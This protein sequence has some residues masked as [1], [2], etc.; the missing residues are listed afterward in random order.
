[1]ATGYRPKI[2]GTSRGNTWGQ[3]YGSHGNEDA[4]GALKLGQD[5]PYV[6]ER[7]LGSNPYIQMIKSDFGA[8]C[9][10]SKRPFHV[11]KWTN[12]ET[13]RRMKTVICYEAASV[14]NCCQ[15]CMNDMT[16]GVPLVIRDALMKAAGK[17]IDQLPESEVGQS[18]YFNQKDKEAAL[19]ASGAVGIATAADPRL[20]LEAAAKQIFNG[21]NGGHNGQN[22]HR[23]SSSSSS[24]SSSGQSRKRQRPDESN[25]TTIW[26]ATKIKNEQIL[27][28]EELIQNALVSFGAIRQIRRIENKGFA[29]IEFEQ[30]ADAKTVL[31]S[32]V[33]DIA[34]IAIIM[35]WADKQ[36]NNYNNNNNNNK[37]H[38]GNNSSNNNNS[39]RQ[40]NNNVHA[41][42]RTM[43]AAMQ[44]TTWNGVG[45]AHGYQ[46]PPMPSNMRAFISNNKTNVPIPVMFPIP[47]FEQAK[48][49]YP[50]M[51]HT[52]KSVKE[53][54]KVD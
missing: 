46:V 29:F 39:S 16:Y 42:N 48:I 7:C 9:K 18:F 17:T 23:G 3:Q 52:K 53:S 21:H 10:I 5:F 24:S 31:A 30:A 32:N 44:P 38:N 50:S 45:A 6:C 2:A 49:L 27:P 12:P 54:L 19:V 40:R 14:R 20:Q 41:K 22:N 33:Q 28:S 51:K 1:M 36:P 15:A 13:R 37:R 8:S 25:F 47:T 11:F 26:L 35:K 4:T 43:A 34:G